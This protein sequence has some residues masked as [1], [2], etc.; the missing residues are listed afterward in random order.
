MTHAIDHRPR[1]NAQRRERTR[2]RL[3]EAAMLVVSQKGI[4]VT[5]ISD[6]MKAAAVSRGGFYGHF[7]SMNELLNAIGVELANETIMLIE[8]RVTGICDPAERIASG[9]TLYLQIARTYPQFARF[10]AAAGS[11]VATPNHLIYELLPPH[12]EA[13]RAQGKMAVLSPR[14]AVD[15]IA[16]TVLVALMRIS[17]GQVDATYCSQVIAG[18]LMGLGTARATAIKLSSIEI[19]AIFPP[20]DSLLRQ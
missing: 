11:T 17:H 4:E 12:I 16:G 5:Q 2:R 18:I 8:R 10:V 20:H 14:S 3:L 9:L 7:S 1:V 15:L 6:V 19:D 13:A